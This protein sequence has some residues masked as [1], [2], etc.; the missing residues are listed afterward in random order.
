MA[1]R[2][3]L[4]VSALR[5]LHLVGVEF[6]RR[7][8]R[9]ESVDDASTPM[10]LSTSPTSMMMLSSPTLMMMTLSVVYNGSPYSGSSGTYFSMLTAVGGIHSRLESALPPSRST[11]WLTGGG[12]PLSSYA[13]A[14]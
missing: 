7:C 2:K 10:T 14:R 4:I 5:T 12:L 9:M 11:S 1:V 3:G 13:V 8:R 6:R